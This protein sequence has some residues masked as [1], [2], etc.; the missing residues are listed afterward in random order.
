MKRIFKI[1]CLSI[2]LV[3][4]GNKSENLHSSFDNY[5]NGIMAND[6]ANLEEVIVTGSAKKQDNFVERKLIKNGNISFETEDLQAT[7]TAIIKLIKKHNGYISS[8]NQSNYG[9]RKSVI[10]I[11]RIPSKHFDSIIS[12]ISKN[13]DKFDSKDISISDVTTQYLDVESRLKNKKELEKKYLEILKKANSVKDILEVE[14]ELGKLREDIES[15]EGRFKY[16]KNQVSFSTLNINFYKKEQN[17]SSS[18]GKRIKDG[19]A[20]GFENLKVFFIGLISIWPFIILTIILVF[21]IR[22]SI[23]RKKK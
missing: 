12:G 9:N 3:A 17:V 8:D 1:L 19:F 22:K 7:K 23:K 13:V 21:L 4:C 15:T 18:F 20:N 16:L 11:A 10:L 6:K 14:K 5:A 2:F